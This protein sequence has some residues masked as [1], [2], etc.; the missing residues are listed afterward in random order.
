MGELSGTQSTQPALTPRLCQ[1]WGSPQAGFLMSY[2]HM[3]VFKVSPLLGIEGY[4]DP[5]RLVSASSFEVLLDM[6]PESRPGISRA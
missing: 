3:V 4:L 2:N 6:P 1:V 5:V